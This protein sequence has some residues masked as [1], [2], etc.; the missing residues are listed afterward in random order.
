MNALVANYLYESAF[1]VMTEEIY[2]CKNIGL[3]HTSGITI[4][5][6]NRDFNTGFKKISKDGSLCV[7]CIFI[8]LNIAQNIN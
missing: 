6:K 1:G 4:A 5:K 3:T 7:N 8:S 2:I